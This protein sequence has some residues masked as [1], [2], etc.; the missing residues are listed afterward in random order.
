MEKKPFFN[1]DN[2]IENSEKKAQSRY[3]E[4]LPEAGDINPIAKGSTF[5]DC[6]YNEGAFEELDISQ[7]IVIA[8]DIVRQSIRIDYEKDTDYHLDNLTGDCLT[9]NMAL[10]SYLREL[11]VSVDLGFGLV[12]RRPFDPSDRY[13]SRH[14]V[15][16]AK[17]P[18]GEVYIIDPT[19]A[20]GYGFGQ[21]EKKESGLYEYQLLEKSDITDINILIESRSLLRKGELTIT[22]IMIIEKIAQEHEDNKSFHSWVNEAYYI[23]A[24]FYKNIGDQ[25]NYSVYLNK[26]VKYDKYKSRLLSEEGLDI[27][28]AN[29]LN[30]GKK[31]FKQSIDAAVS[32]WEAE[33]MQC[34]AQQKPEK[35]KR[36]LY[37]L[38][39]IQNELNFSEGTK[40]PTF[41][42]DGQEISYSDLT[43]RLV[44]DLGL[45]TL[46]I[47]PSV[48]VHGVEAS[49][50]D[51][52]KKFE[53][54]DSYEIDITKEGRLGY[55]PLIAGHPDGQKNRRLF[56]GVSYVY[57][58]RANKDD[59]LSEKKRLR[60][61]YG[62]YIGSTIKWSDGLPI[63]WPPSLLNHVHSTDNAPEA[64][65]HF[66][67]GKPE[68]SSINRWSY[69]NIRL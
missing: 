31:C 33:A 67:V 1:P 62:K 8:N 52:L 36:G 7:R 15:T 30:E 26:A 12:K 22:D 46:W 50:K 25:N 65:L 49:I 17:T 60:S 68:Y 66:M 16:E 54:I 23:I 38:Q 10:Q 61:K 24:Q 4:F 34:F 53:V 55:S 63:E 39:C 2:N 35:T 64:V 40:P 9:A 11:G 18:E 58:L 44:H 51:E 19:P 37:L 6:G 32:D 41:S 69:P 45:T 3:A 48:K 42:I 5:S 20:V 29:L 56:D 27:Q 21:V 28:S 59:V 14:I 57:L 47:K 43:P 13:T